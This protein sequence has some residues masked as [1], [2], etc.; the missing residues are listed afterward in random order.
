MVL[1]KQLSSSEFKREEEAKGFEVQL[2]GLQL[3][4]HSIAFQKCLPFWISGQKLLFSFLQAF[5]VDYHVIQLFLLHGDTACLLWLA[6]V[7]NYPPFHCL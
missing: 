3:V 5:F 2:G 4:T 6:L 7:E 1:V